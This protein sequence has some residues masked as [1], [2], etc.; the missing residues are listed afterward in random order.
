MSGYCSWCAE[1]AEPVDA[2]D[3]KSGG[4]WPR[5]GSTPTFGIVGGPWVPP[6]APP[7]FS[8]SRLA[9]VSPPAGKARLRRRLERNRDWRFLGSREE[10]TSHSCSVAGGG[11]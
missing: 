4:A 8:L 10:G 1:V 5:V 2:P 7:F 9:L 3:S 11:R 6:R